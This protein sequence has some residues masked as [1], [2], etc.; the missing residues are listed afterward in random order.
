[1]NIETGPTKDEKVKKNATTLSRLLDCCA[2]D[3]REERAAKVAAQSAGQEAESLQESA[4]MAACTAPLL[5]PRQGPREA[6]GS[7]PGKNRQRTKKVNGAPNRHLM[8][9][10]SGRESRECLD[11]A[12]GKRDPAS[13]HNSRVLSSAGNTCAARRARRS[14]SPN[15]GER[16]SSNSTRADSSTCARFSSLVSA[17]FQETVRSL[18]S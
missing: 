4:R 11:G 18:T 15:P 8:T 7:M 9:N 2:A 16:S 13:L 14:C 10:A 12:L 5:A 3:C 6:V 17:S 1:M